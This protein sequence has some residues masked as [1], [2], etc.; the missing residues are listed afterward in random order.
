MIGLYVNIMRNEECK[1]ALAKA[2]EALNDLH[3]RCDDAI[4]ENA[5][6]YINCLIVTYYRFT[7][8][9]TKSSFALLKAGQLG[10]IS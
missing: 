6:D 9:L 1:E 2:K 8:K 10:C 4:G 3:E 5:L 7:I